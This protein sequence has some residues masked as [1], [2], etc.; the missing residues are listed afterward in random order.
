MY[1]VRL[2]GSI[3]SIREFHIDDLPAVM[4]VVGDE[5]VTEWLSFDKRSTEQASDMLRGIICRAQQEPRNEYYLAIESLDEQLVGFVRLGLAGTC[6]GK[7]GYAIAAVYWGC[8]L[9]TDAVHTITDFGFHTLGLHRISAAM[10]PDNKASLA[11]AHNLGMQYEGRIRDHVFTNG[12]WRDSLLYSVLAHE[13]PPP[14][15]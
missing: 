9:A 5:R 7:L 2:N 1:P 10:G 8:K 14:K 4:S 3:T 12:Q 13:W 6:A 15:S 11:I